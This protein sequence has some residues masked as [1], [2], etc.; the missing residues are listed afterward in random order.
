[1]SQRATR[2][3]AFLKLADLSEASFDGRTDA[4]GLPDSDGVLSMDKRGWA[5]EREFVRGSGD[6]VWGDRVAQVK[7]RFKSGRLE[8]P[9]MVDFAV[10]KRHLIIY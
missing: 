8:G 2:A 10:H 1:M 7:G 5:E 6:T 3:R 9:A 4:D